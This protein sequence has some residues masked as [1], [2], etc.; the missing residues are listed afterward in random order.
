MISTLALAFALQTAPALSI[1][2][3]SSEGALA[4]QVFLES[5]T[6]PVARALPSAAANA[7]GPQAYAA[8]TSFL[9][10]NQDPEHDMPR[11]VAFRANGSEAVIVGRDTDTVSF[12]DVASLTIAHTVSVGDFPVH[13]A[14]TPDDHYAL[15]PNVF[16]NSLSVIDLATHSLAATVALTGDQPYRVA[17]TSDSLFAVVGV[18]E[19][20]TNSRA[21]VVDLTSMSEVRSFA[22]TPQGVFGGFATP[23][24]GIFGNLFTQFDLSA[25]DRTLVLPDRFNSQVALFD[26]TNGAQIALLPTATFPTGVDVSLD[27]TLAVVEHEDGGGTISKLDLV[28]PAVT[29][30]FATGNTMYGGHVVVTHDKAFAIASMLNEVQFV[31][32]ASGATS[33]VVGT[34]TV[35]DIELSFDGQ[36]AIVSNFNTRVIS[37][38]TQSVVKVMTYASCYD[39]AASPVEQRFVAL[40]NRFREDIHLYDTNGAAG[41]FEGAALSGELEEGDAPRSLAISADGQTALV[42]N[43]TSSNVAIVDVATG[44]VRAYVPTGLRSLGAAI[45]PDGTTAVVANAGSDSATVI[46]LTTDTAVAQLPVPQVPAEVVISPDGTTA[47]VTSLAGTDRLHIIDLAGAA[48]SVSSSLITGQMGS[49]GYTYSVFSGLSISPDGATVALCISFDDQVM[50][51]DT[52]SGTEIARLAVGDFPIRARF[53]PDS[54]RLYVT[55]SF[56]DSVVAIDVNGAASSVA[57]SVGGIDFPLQVD[58]DAAGAFCYVGSFNFSTPSLRVIDTSSLLQVASVALSGPP[59]SSAW[60]GAELL[61]TSSDGG[62]Q[63]V[64]AAGAASAVVES[65]PLTG[66][67]SDMVFSAASGRAFCAQPGA[68]DGLDVIDFGSLTSSYCSSLP[69]SSGAPAL[70]GSSGTTSI[71]ANAFHVSVSSASASQPGLFYYG[72]SQVQLAFGNGFRCVAG[73]VHRLNPPSNST[74]SGTNSRLVDFTQPPANGGPGQILVGSTWNFQYWFRDPLG[75]GA[76]FDLSDGLSAT[77]VP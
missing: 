11:D 77:F 76:V 36:F 8:T 51:V 28:A 67:P 68:Q 66:S 24:P 73:S 33:A 52:A 27:G 47:Y 55:H 70:I 48:S 14:V 69:N 37:V 12:F 21:S 50:L 19:D 31:D 2:S 5:A 15:V 3:T 23:E 39:G 54:S 74:P 26:I 57:G 63:R 16:G 22:T 9:S 45:S 64:D 30:S 56:G 58:V 75:G 25:D 49:I 71:G 65:L 20:G 18:I 61:V 35:G 53:S 34:G 60:S 32:L 7:V 42:V 41:F 17:V 38:A 13:V 62:L 4:P 43:N 29:G 59:R 72:S 40:N 6:R 10:V 1:E 46:D 44:S